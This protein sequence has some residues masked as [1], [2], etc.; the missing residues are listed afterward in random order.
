MNNSLRFTI[1]SYTNVLWFIITMILSFFIYNNA[2]WLIGDDA[3]LIDKTGKCIPFSIFDSICYSPSEGRFFPMAYL[4][5]NI[6]LLFN[7]T[8]ISAIQHYIL[9][10]IGF[11]F[12]SFFIY[13]TTKDIIKKVDSKVLGNVVTLLFTFL[14]LQ[15]AYITF[16]FLFT[17]IWIDYLLIAGFLFFTYRFIETN[18]T[19]NAI[20]SIIF[21]FYF[22]F[23]L[24]VNFIIPGVFGTILMIFSSMNKH[25]KNFIFGLTLFTLAFVF[26]IIYYF[27][28]YRHITIVYDGAHGSEDSFLTNSIKMLLAQKIIIISFIILGI[29]LYKFYTN[30]GAFHYFFDTSLITGIVF[31]IG[32]LYLKLNWNMYYVIPVILVGFPTL[33]TLINI[34]NLKSSYLIISLLSLFYVRNFA[35]NILTI[36]NLRLET[37]TIV[38]ELDSFYQNNYKFIWKDN[39]QLSG[40]DKALTNW[41][42]ATFL[43]FIKQEVNSNINFEANSSSDN[44]KYI[45]FYPEE[46]KPLNLNSKSKL[47]SQISGI[48]VIKQN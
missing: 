4:A 16:N 17:T 39:D 46:S 43:T 3:V 44:E 14:I 11:I 21:I 28:I 18:K 1:S 40:W 35:D 27:F 36:Q 47:I 42:R 29:R 25:K 7:N 10:A 19:I 20:F 34:S 33:N 13:S 30:N 48:T 2:T 31:T 24:E 38:K 22:T 6:L 41:R 45:F 5:Y 8:H 37:S 15:R 26:L 12:F 32:C 23:C 9:I